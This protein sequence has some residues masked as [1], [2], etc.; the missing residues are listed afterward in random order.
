MRD[1]FLH[2]F[3]FYF[4][5]LTQQ[6]VTRKKNLFFASTI[7]NVFVGELDRVQTHLG[8]Q[9]CTDREIDGNVLGLC[10]QQ[11]SIN[12]VTLYANFCLY[13]CS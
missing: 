12:G 1:G 10:K 6:N 7:L 9:S 13:L 3:H 5:P 8:L 11:V 2:I 4:V